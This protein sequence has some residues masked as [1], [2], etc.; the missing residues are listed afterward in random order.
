MKFSRQELKT[1]LLPI[2]LAQAF[3]V[4]CG[5]IGVKVTSQFVLPTDLGRYGVLLTFTTTGAMIVHA[6]LIKYV[7]RHW[8]GTE[9]QPAMFVGAIKSWWNKLPWLLLPA[10]GGGI[11]V[12][13][14]TAIFGI[15]VAAA[16]L[17]LFALTQAALQA[18]RENWRDGSVVVGAALTR[19]F[20]PPL[21]YLGIGGLWIGLWIGF[22]GHALT[23]AAGGIWALRRHWRGRHATAPTTKPTAVYTGTL[24]V[25]LAITA[26]ALN[27]L[28][29]WLV[30][31]G[32]GVE[33]AGYYTLASS[34]GLILPTVLGGVFIQYR[35]PV[36]FALAD[37]P[38]ATPAKLIGFVDRMTLAYT[39]ITLLCLALLHWVAPLLVGPLIAPAYLPALPWILPAGCFG[40][41]LISGQFYHTVLLAGRREIACG[42]VDL[43]SA[44]VL[45][46][47]CSLSALLSEDQFRIWLA[48]SILV[49]WLIKRPLARRALLK[50][51]EAHEPAPDQ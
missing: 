42:P 2:L 14:L 1:H 45:V 15:F 13:S 41:T 17:A 28:A 9:N 20:A 37:K 30:A 25:T 11:A 44:G 7:A 16:L 26:W 33:T 21:L 19:T 50:T 46:L 8:A 3:G 40:L 18:T 27:G 35:Q 39:A 31:A 12:G 29:R 49:P 24:F 47:G 34:I 6:G 38:D 4:A 36:L 43:I 48:G 5:I 32:F 23:A 51:G 10:I 22:V